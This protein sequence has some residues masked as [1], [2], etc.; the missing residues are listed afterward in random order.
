MGSWTALFSGS[1]GSAYVEENS[2]IEGSTNAVTAGYGPVAGKGI[3]STTVTGKSATSSYRQTNTTDGA[4]SISSLG[5]ITGS[6]SDVS[7]DTY[8]RAYYYLPTNT[9]AG[10]YLALDWSDSYVDYFACQAVSG[11]FIDSGGTLYA[12][13]GQGATVTADSTSSGAIPFGAWFRLEVYM[14]NGQCTTVRIFKGANVDGTT[15]DI[16]FTPSNHYYSILSDSSDGVYAGQVNRQIGFMSLD[17][18]ADVG[19]GYQPLINDVGLGS[20]YYMSAVDLSTS[21]WVGP[22]GGGGTSASVTQV[23]ATVTATGG[24]Q[25]VAT[26]RIAAVTQSAATVTA[27][28]GTQSVASVQNASVT[29]VAGTV[30]AT[31]GTQVITTGSIVSAS[32]TQVAATVTAT[33]GTQAVASVQ[34]ASV[35]QV[36][37]NVTATGG[38][39]TLTSVQNATITQAFAAI[40]AQGGTQTVLGTSPAAYTLPAEPLYFEVG[41]GLS[42]PLGN[43]AGQIAYSAAAPT[44]TPSGYLTVY[45][46]TH[47]VLYVYNVHSAAWK[48]VALT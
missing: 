48:S 26:T 27:T 21:T 29:Q 25:S 28:G 47:D 13:F 6:P 1:N 20:S 9:L 14:H 35:S 37:A 15:P 33:G 3:Y 10:N 16:T 7:Y 17:I 38:T 19:F 11:L 5:N 45:D 44:G 40:T 42:L 8:T 36:A 4:D 30:T 32:I 43:S 12:G 39:Q 18:S 41:G 2:W 46:Y 31:G 34:N 22:Y 23:H 24:T